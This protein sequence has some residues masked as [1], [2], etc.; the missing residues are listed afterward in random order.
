[1]SVAA[2]AAPAAQQHP[3][4]A[5]AMDVE[6]LRLFNRL[7]AAA[8]HEGPTS[9]SSEATE[10]QPAFPRTPTP[11]D[12]RTTCDAIRDRLER[13]LRA[14]AGD[15]WSDADTAPALLT[16]RL[17]ASER[18]RIAHLEVAQLALRELASTIE[19]LEATQ[20]RFDITRGA[21]AMLLR[22]YRDS[23]APGSMP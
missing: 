17:A 4:L 23:P 10:V 11:A 9:E 7:I 12:R 3:G 8:L 13:E 16:A 6:R 1:M 5:S 15:T 22:I 20:A 18:R 2:G 14:E 19:Q 21:W